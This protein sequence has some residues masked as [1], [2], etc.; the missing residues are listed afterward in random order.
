[1]LL[2]S[3]C[4]L[5][6]PP[7]TPITVCAGEGGGVRRFSIKSCSPKSWVNS[8]SLTTSSMTTQ[9][10]SV[11]VIVY[12]NA[13]PISSFLW[14]DGILPLSKKKTTP[15]QTNTCSV[16]LCA[17]FCHLTRCVCDFFYSSAAFPAYVSFSRR[18]KKLLSLRKKKRGKKALVS[19]STTCLFFIFKKN[20]ENRR[21]EE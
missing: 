10:S 21:W 12:M 3:V 14:E 15:P 13:N 5:S 2:C 1:M 18:I 11:F 8:S 17:F 19:S 6:L 7:L 4:V 20:R 9:T 16:L